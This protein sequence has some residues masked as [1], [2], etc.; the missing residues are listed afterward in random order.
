MFET[1]THEEPTPTKP[2][3][4]ERSIRIKLRASKAVLEHFKLESIPDTPSIAVPCAID[5]KGLSEVVKHFLLNESQH[6]QQLQMP[7]QFEFLDIDRTV[8]LRSTMEKHLK[9]HKITEED[10]V[11]IEYSIPRSQNFSA[12][13]PGAP[14]PDWISSLSKSASG[15]VVFSGSFDGSIVVSKQQ[16]GKG[17]V[18]QSELTNAHPSPVTSVAAFQTKNGATFVASASKDATVQ[19]RQLA[20]D[21]TLSQS[22]LA[23]CA[24]QTSQASFQSVSAALSGDNADEVLLAAAGWGGNIYFFQAPLSSAEDDNNNKK[25]KPTAIAPSCVLQGHTDNVSAAIWA[26]R[27]DPV[28]LYSAGWDMTCRVWDCV[29]QVQTT[30]LTC[31]KAFTSLDYSQEHQLLVSGHADNVV[32]LWDARSGGDAVVKMNLKGHR[33]WVS[34]VQF[35]PNGSTRLASASYDRTVK[36]WDIRG[37]GE[38]QTIQTDVAGRLFACAWGEDSRLYLGGTDSV[39]RT[40]CADKA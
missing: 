1:V 39:L 7:Q 15:G 23:T 16:E 12:E 29:R 5:R 10:L 14:V 32:R 34:S 28:T 17:L 37:G 11:Q 21:F 4:V 3:E 24:V 33:G 31:N 6:Q 40:Y 8:L 2:M 19:V 22:A 20:N 36:V 30:V 13:G 27:V 26:S 38:I 9:K 18:V 25:Q 35:E